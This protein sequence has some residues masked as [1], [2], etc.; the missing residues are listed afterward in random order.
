M[1]P[2]EYSVR[3]FYDQPILNSPYEKPRLHHPLDEQGQ[4]LG[5]APTAGR[6]PSKFIVPVPKAKKGGG[7]QGALDLDTYSDNAIINEIRAHVDAWR[8][9][10][11]RA[12]W[13][14]TPTTQRLLEH[15]RHH[16]F[17]NQ[18]PFFCQI[19]AV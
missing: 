11:G 2:W 8:D 1:P 7:A 6:R 3:T 12:D 4:P 17:A 5:I 15:W 13:G 19:E 10:P 9:L 16:R 14:V 18:R